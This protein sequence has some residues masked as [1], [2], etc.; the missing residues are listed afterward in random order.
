M[1]KSSEYLRRADSCAELAALATNRPSKKRFERMEAAW[2]ALAE[3]QR[4][5]DGEIPPPQEAVASSPLHSS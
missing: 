1:S 5:L 4:W 3:E 2:R